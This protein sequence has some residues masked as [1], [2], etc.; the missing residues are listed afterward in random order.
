MGTQAMAAQR[1]CSAHPAG[2]AMYSLI[3][4]LY[5]ICRS[6]TGDG[7]RETLRILG[8]QIPIEMHEVP[9]GT[10]AF[11]WTVPQEW[12]I[13][14]AWIRRKRD[15]LVIAD[16]ARSN[17]HVMSYSVPVHGVFSLERLRQH[18]FTLP[19]HPAWIPYRT[20]Y[21]D[22]NWAFCLSHEQLLAM[23]DGDYEVLIDSRLEDGSLTYGECLLE[24][25]TPDEILISAH[26]CHPSMCNDNLSGIAVAAALARRLSEY[27][28]RHTFRFVFAPAT[29]G[30]IT[31]IAGHEVALGRIRAGLV[32]SCVG[33]AGPFTYKRSRRGNAQVDRAVE[34]VLKTSGAA[35]RVRDF[36]P[37]G[38]DERQYCSP[39]FELPVGSFLR[40]PNGEYPEYHTSA[41]NLDLVRPE[42]LAG[43]LET[44]AAVMEVLEG[45][46]KYQ[47]L[48]PYCE[49]QL[50]RR[51]LYRAVGGPDVES[52]HLAM[53][54]VL[55]FSDGKHDLL[56]IAERSGLS[57]EAVHSAAALLSA[58]GLLRKLS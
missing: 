29:I 49:P 6:I 48:Q 46:G 33:D 34:H 32:L 21:F 50:G 38:Y 54:W 47:N 1:A 23:E 20:S 8:E 5:P 18:I 52:T 24:G 12:N 13:R 3:S 57:F 56:A 30:A 43:S 37:Y 16:L 51:G 11:D 22:R 2:E 44:L 42:A 25:S 9:S 17:L 58:H 53:L 15:G 19:G 26:V 7:V 27:P 55:N 14:D 10:R 35:Y 39:A 31:W 45:N 41:D 40:T 36:S 28:R 4:R